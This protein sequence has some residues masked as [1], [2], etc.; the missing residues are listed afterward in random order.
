MERES[1][2]EKE[3]ERERERERKREKE[4]TQPPSFFFCSSQICNTPCRR[5]Q[6]LLLLVYQQKQVN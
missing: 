1:E 5:K 6:T 4:S 3:S 2:G